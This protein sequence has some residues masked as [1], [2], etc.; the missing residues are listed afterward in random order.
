VERVPDWELE[1]RVLVPTWLLALIHCCDLECLSS[2]FLQAPL[3]KGG[4]L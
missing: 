2:A 3:C 1:A 4:L